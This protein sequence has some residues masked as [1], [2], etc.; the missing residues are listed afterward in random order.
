MSDSRTPHENHKLARRICSEFLEMPGLR[1]TCA[2]AQRLFGLS[3]Q[4]C[5]PLLEELVA[6]KFLARRADGAYGV[7]SSEGTRVDARRDEEYTVVLE[8]RA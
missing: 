4:I 3:E 5:R 6:H 7:P 1:L 8:R 2:Q